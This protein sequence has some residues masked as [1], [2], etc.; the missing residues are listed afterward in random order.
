MPVD[1]VFFLVK[2]V[3]APILIYMV[4]SSWS[5]AQGVDPTIG[6]IIGAAAA[7]GTIV[8]SFKIG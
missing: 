6:N 4:V 1:I 2:H 7:F 5:I 3:L 8:V